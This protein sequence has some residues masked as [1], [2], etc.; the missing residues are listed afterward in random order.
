MLLEFVRRVSNFPLE[1]AL[2]GGGSEQNG[3]YPYVRMEEILLA[4]NATKSNLILEWYRPNA[5]D[6]LLRGTHA[7]LIKVA[8]PF[9]TQ[10]CVDNKHPRDD[11]CNPDWIIRV[12]DASGVCD[13]AV[14]NL[15]KIISKG[16]YD[17]S[18]DPTV[19][20]AA[21]SPAYE[22]LRNFL[23]ASLQLGGIFQNQRTAASPREAICQF[24]VDN[25]DSLLKPLVPRSHPRTLKEEPQAGLTY[26]SMALGLLTCLLVVIVTAWVYTR[27]HRRV[28]RYAQI[29]FFVVAALRWFLSR[30]WGYFGRCTR[31][32]C[33]LHLRSVVRQCWVYTH[34]CSIDAKGSNNQQ[35]HDGFQTNDE[36]HD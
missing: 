20:E 6:E 24:A 26:F 9:P 7:E 11:I 35:A 32:R 27:R 18:Y 10:E 1:I 19:A 31:Y 21:Q 5:L 30:S 2:K 14:A 33:Y 4:A 16:L 25:F 13:D 22:V 23:I 36:S 28:I 12:G 15:C 34:A 3:G 17:S 29:Y 8:L